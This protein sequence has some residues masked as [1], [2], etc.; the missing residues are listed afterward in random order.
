[1][2]VNSKYY[3]SEKM[4]D[5]ITG[6]RGEQQ[7]KNAVI[8]PQISRTISVVWFKMQRMSVQTYVSDDRI[9]KTAEQIREEMG[10][11]RNE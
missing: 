11:E 6:S 7:G 4:V 9:P 2:A 3:L 10:F 8:N 1:M 5:Y